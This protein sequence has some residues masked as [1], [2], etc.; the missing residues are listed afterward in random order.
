MRMMVT[1]EMRWLAAKYVDETLILTRQFMRE[2]HQRA[3]ILRHCQI[4]SQQAVS[5]QARHL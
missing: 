2:F 5:R 3:Y 1:V 4:I